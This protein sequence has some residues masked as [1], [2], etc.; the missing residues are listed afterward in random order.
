MKTF[1]ALVAICAGNSPVPG[2]FPTQRPVTRSFDVF[3]DL[4][5]NKR[6][7]KQSWGC[8]FGKPANSLWRHSNVILHPGLILDCMIS[9]VYISFII[10]PASTKLKGGILVSPCPSVRLSVRPSVRLSVCGQNRVRSVSST[11]L[12]GSISYLHILLSNFRR[13][14]AWNARFKVQ[15]LKFWRIS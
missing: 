3:F 1:S 14:V 11:I 9:G 12:I 15:T 4:R 13:C 5:V 6:L 10:P 8:W 2:E 7:S